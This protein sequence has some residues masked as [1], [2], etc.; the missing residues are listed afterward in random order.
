MDKA[1]VRAALTRLSAVTVQINETDRCQLSGYARGHQ[2]QVSW[3]KRVGAPTEN[4]YIIAGNGRIL[5]ADTA[6]EAEAA[7]V[8]LVDTLR[9]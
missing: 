4:S 1:V 2:V 7:M 3:S 5:M 8:A 9:G 6:K